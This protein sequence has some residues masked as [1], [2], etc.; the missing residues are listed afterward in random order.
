MSF[1]VLKS[2]R[3]RSS[4]MAAEQWFCNEEWNPTIEEHFFKK[5]SRAKDKAQYL[6]IQAG[7]LSKRYPRVALELLNKFFAL[8]G[9]SI[10]RAEALLHEAQAYLSLGAKQKAIES[11]QTALQ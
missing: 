1:D 11:L 7:C 10:F 8:E 9:N 6:K 3:S 5:L 4:L 2:P